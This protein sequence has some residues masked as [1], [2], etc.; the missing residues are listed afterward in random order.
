VARD[1]EECAHVVATPED[2]GDWRD[3]PFDRDDLPCLPVEAADVEW[4]DADLDAAFGD[5]APLLEASDGD[6]TSQPE[7]VRLFAAWADSALL[8]LISIGWSDGTCARPAATTITR[9]ILP[10]SGER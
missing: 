10:P 3:D 2:W 5:L 9:R 1:P 6:L 8:P 4:S 7:S